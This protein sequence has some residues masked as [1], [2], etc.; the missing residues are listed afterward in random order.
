MTEH[1]D[2]VLLVDDEPRLLSSL[3]RRL[4]P[5]YSILTAEGGPEAL[6]LLAQRADVKVIVA[7]MQMPEMNGI[8]LLKH[9]KVSHP[10]IRRVML[11][12]NSDQETAVAAINEGEVMR[13][14]R[15][16][17]N[18][19]ELSA[20]LRQ[21]VDEFDFE[22]SQALD[23]PDTSSSE[24]SR[25]ELQKMLNRELD[26]QLANMIN[27][28]S[29]LD[30]PPAELES[31]DL[32]PRLSGVKHSGENVLWL[33]GYMMKLS[34]LKTAHANNTMA[35]RFELTTAARAEI[36]ELREEIEAK[37][38]TV[39]FNSLRKN[40]EVTGLEGELRMVI[41]ELLRSAIRYN[42]PHGHISVNVNC[43]REQAAIRIFSTGACIPPDQIQYANEAWTIDD[44]HPS[45]DR[46]GL[47]LKILLAV[48]N[49]NQARCEV[50]PHESGGMVAL[51]NMKRAAVG[52]AG[53]MEAAVA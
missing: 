10:K 8:E 1:L 14:L 41:S 3:R 2:V 45:K 31:T 49:V 30:V 7:D 36:E 24:V 33:V 18:S 51:I 13:F 48:S 4:S 5:S 17:C 16:P 23:L 26:C 6:Q 52:R 28:S 34:Q 35:S 25:H 29:T 46:D 40:V 11:T 44:A 20:I 22:A 50:S 47:S 12:G 38:L 15:K 21:A 32:H 53:L 19:E 43:E 37:S 42:D 27:L 39:S 9:V